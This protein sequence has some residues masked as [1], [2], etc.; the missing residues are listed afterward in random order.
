[1]TTRHFQSFDLS[2]PERNVFIRTPTPTNEDLESMSRPTSALREFFKHNKGLFI[3]A[4]SQFFFSLMN[5]SVKFLTALNEPVPTLEV[6][7]FCFQF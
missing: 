7:F 3:I 6:S 4:A 2:P 5:L 1:M